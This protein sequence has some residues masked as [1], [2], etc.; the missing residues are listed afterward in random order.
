VTGLPYLG[1]EGQPISRDE[2]MRLF[3]DERHIGEDHIG[4][5]CVSTV[6]M[7]IDHQFGDGPPLIFETMIFG[8]VLDKWQQRYSTEREARAG[9][10][11]AL[12]LVR[13]TVGIT[14]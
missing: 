4:D 1:W 14:G 8:G 11:E 13:E 9:H 7:G 3:E 10:A 12:A 6:W 5:V 2:W